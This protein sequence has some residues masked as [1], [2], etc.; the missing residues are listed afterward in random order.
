MDL[1]LETRTIGAKATDLTLS[2][3]GAHNPR[4]IAVGLFELQS[5]RKFNIRDLLDGCGGSQCRPVKKP[6]APEQNLSVSGHF[7]FEG[8]KHGTHHDLP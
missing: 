8:A 7:Q 1:F 6:A 2:F 5:P 3:A 4:A